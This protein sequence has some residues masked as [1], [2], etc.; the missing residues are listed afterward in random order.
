MQDIA[1]FSSCSVVNGTEVRAICC[2][3]K[4]QTSRYRPDIRFV[5]ELANDGVCPSPLCVC[6]CVCAENS[7]IWKA[8]GLLYGCTVTRLCRSIA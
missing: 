1:D 8:D 5:R 3:I 2:T 7:T 6:V 4:H